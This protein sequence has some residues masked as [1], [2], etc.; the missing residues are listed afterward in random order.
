M[1]NGGMQYGWSC[2]MYIS[3]VKPTISIIH[4]KHDSLN[5]SRLEFD[6]SEQQRHAVPKLKPRK[7]RNPDRHSVRILAN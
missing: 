2:I 3:I 4:M 1:K 5:Y 7:I 6:N